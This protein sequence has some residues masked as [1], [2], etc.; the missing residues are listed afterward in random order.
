MPWGNMGGWTAI[1]ILIVV[2][3]LFG[4]AKLPALAKSAGQSFKIFKKEMKTGAAD[5]DDATGTASTSTAST[6]TASPGTASTVS[7][8][9]DEPTKPAD[10]PTT[11]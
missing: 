1:V 10:P 7:S 4:A 3:L 11:S 6:G 8:D 9:A 2:L 5:G